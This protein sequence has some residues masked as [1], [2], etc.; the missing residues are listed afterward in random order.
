MN[1]IAAPVTCVIPTHN[2]P[3]FLENAL[4]S[5]ADQTI[6]PAELIVVDDARCPDT[7]SL[8]ERA[9]VGCFRGISVKY[10]DRTQFSS[11]GPGASASRNLGIRMASEAYL[12]FLDDDDVWHPA[13][14]EETLRIFHERDCQFVVAW[15]DLWD[16]SHTQP[17]HRIRGGLAANDALG[18]NPGLTGS[19]FVVQSALA[20][21]IGGFDEQL[22]VAN[23]KD[24][25]VRLLDSGAD[26][27]VVRRPLVKQRVHSAGQLT[28]RTQR[29]VDGLRAF[30]AKYSSRLNWRNR[31]D[32]SHA[33]SSVE[34]VIAVTRARRARALVVQC[35]TYSLPGLA[36]AFGRRLRPQN[37]R[38]R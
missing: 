21:R 18:V 26:Y 23:D 3:E 16:G 13:F 29:R 33:I 7:R 32:I 9:G 31:R 28:G 15:T 22:Y 30:E 27:G 25:L 11:S 19:N 10:V 8:T 2:R 5:V 37:L 38:Y 24:F 14:L 12:A 4:N 20:R 6:W 35:L 36:A 1:R 17:G 34:R